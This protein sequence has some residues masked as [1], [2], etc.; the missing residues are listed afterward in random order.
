MSA[1][2]MNGASRT[3]ERGFSLVE[4]MIAMVLGLLVIGGTVTVFGGASRSARLNEALST[5]QANA[6]FALDSVTAD[7]RMAGFRG[8]ADPSRAALLVGAANPPT[9]NLE[10]TA[11]SGWL[12]GASGWTPAAPAGYTPPAAGEAGA[13]VPGTHALRLQYAALPGYP[14]ASSMSGPADDLSVT[15]TVNDL[16]ENDF[17]VVA[18]CNAAELFAVGNL[19]R[20]SGT[21]T[22]EPAAQLSQAWHAAAEPSATSVVMPFVDAL[23]YVG[24]T[25][26][27]NATGDAIRALYLQ[28]F[29]HDVA[30][31]ELV[32]GV[33]QMRLEFGVEMGAGL[34]FL[35]PDAPGLVQADVRLVRLG[36]L[37]AS[38]E[39]F[40]EQGSGSAVRL[41]GQPVLPAAAGLPAGAITYPADSRLRMAFDTTVAVRNRAVQESP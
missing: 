11:V 38:P 41:A 21:A 24:D 22:L 28:G 36:L 4:L 19:T 33:E 26:R 17:A 20:G 18:N 37:M 8:C 10:A 34:A 25:G 5:L 40:P 32:E 29:P 16:R 15:G 30:P 27:T 2:A 12:V 7:L 35:Q 3:P 23:Y 31:L 14:L 13:P 9:T 6:R 39:R 1:S